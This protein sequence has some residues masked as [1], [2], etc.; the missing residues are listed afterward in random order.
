MKKILFALFIL[1]GAAF[2]CF[3][4]SS[5]GAAKFSIGVDAAAPNGVVSNV[6]TAGF[7]ASVKAELPVGADLFATGSV[8]YE[9]FFVKS[10]FKVYGYSS[11]SGFVPIKA[12]LK[13]YFNE[14]LFGEAQAGASVYTANNG[15]TAFAYSAGMGYTFDGGFEIGVRYEAWQKQGTFGQAALRLAYR[16]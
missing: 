11:S 1:G 5:D 8:G 10:E 9:A 4:Q 3:A 13:Y 14:S 2:N 7:G 15:G 12:G 16:F 6:Y